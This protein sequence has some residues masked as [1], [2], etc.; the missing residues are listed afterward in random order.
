M[1][2]KL[3]VNADVID[4]WN[5]QLMLCEFTYYEQNIIAVKLQKNK[6]NSFLFHSLFL[7]NIYWYYL[8]I[9]STLYIQLDY[10]TYW[11]VY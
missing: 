10:G 11:K 8:A 1:Y 3:M 4:L 5:I 2:T 6:N 7:R 9:Y